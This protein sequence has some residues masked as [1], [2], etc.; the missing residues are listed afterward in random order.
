MK[1]ILLLGS[2]GYFGKYLINS[3]DFNFISASRSKIN[4]NHNNHIQLD[5]LKDDLLKIFKNYKFDFII[6]LVTARP[7]E[8]NIS[9]HKNINSRG[10]INIIN[11][12]NYLKIPLIHFSSVAI[13]NKNKSFYDYGKKLSENVISK[14]LNYGIVLR[15]SAIITPDYPN[16]ILI[17]LLRK[18]NFLEFFLPKKI[19]EYKLNGPIY[20]LDVIKVIK[21][22]LKKKFIYR[23]IKFYDLIGPDKL[24]LQFYLK[25]KNNKK[26]CKSRIKN[27]L[28]VKINSIFN[29]I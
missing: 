9:F 29:Y 17:K 20:F 26:L 12:A 24:K 5:I 16:L 4:V 6:N 14:N 7:D 23:K 13:Y 11:L 2:T 8:K 28:N 18:F 27:F 1:K 3:E 10:I 19:K 22:I 21:V 25:N 15:L